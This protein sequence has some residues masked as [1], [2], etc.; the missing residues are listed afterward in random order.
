MSKYYISLC[1]PSNSCF[2][3]LALLRYT[4]GKTLNMAM[5]L[6]KDAWD[7]RFLT[8]KNELSKMSKYYINLCK[9]SDSWFSTLALLSYTVEKTLK[10]TKFLP[11]DAWDWRFLTSK[12]ELSKMSKYCISLCKPQDSWFST[13]AV[14]RYTV[15]K[16]LKMTMFLPKDA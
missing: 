3:T 9:P 16:T 1:K 6:P 15:E 4:V 2:S 14:L 10:M 8:S 12:N 7:W 11:K 13:L 5:V